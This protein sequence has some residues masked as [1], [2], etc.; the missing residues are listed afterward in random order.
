MLLIGTKLYGFCG[1]WFG[2]DAYSD[3]RVEGVGADWVVARQENGE[4]LF[5]SGEDIHLELAPYT[6]QPE[7]GGL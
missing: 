4:A 7:E 5:A 2:H 3:K 1:G 6:S